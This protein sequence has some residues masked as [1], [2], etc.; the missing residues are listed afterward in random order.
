[1]STIKSSIK[2]NIHLIGV[3]T[4]TWKYELTHKTDGF[5]EERYQKEFYFNKTKDP[6]AP[7]ITK[8]LN[9]ELDFESVVDLGCYI[10]H[11]INEF[12]NIG[13]EICGV[14]GDWIDPVVLLPEVREKVVLHNLEK[15]LDLERKFDL[16]M[17]L[18]TAENINPGTEQQF[19]KNM[20]K[21]AGRYIVF[22]AARIGQGAGGWHQHKCFHTPSWWASELE[23][24]GANYLL[25][26]T[27]TLAEKLDEANVP[28]WYVNNI[29][30]FRVD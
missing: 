12:Q 22:S 17:S 14:D 26:E 9:E 27:A 20:V 10:G 2:K 28:E 29:S 11:F 18:E 6:N 15:P 21:H 3:K 25:H 7:K 16:V 8:V 19:L 30:L 13:K 1:M 23:K 24:M 4:K 5:S